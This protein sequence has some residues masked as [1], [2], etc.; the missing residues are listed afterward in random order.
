MADS[1]FVAANK[2][3][4][5]AVQDQNFTTNA[6]FARKSALQTITTTAWRYPGPVK[7][8]SFQNPLNTGT[9]KTQ[10]GAVKTPASIHVNSQEMMLQV[11]LIGL[12][13]FGMELKSKNTIAPVVTYITGA[14]TTVVASSGTVNGLEL[15][16]ATNFAQNQMIEIVMGSGVNAHVEYRRIETLSG[17]VVTFDYPLFVAPADGVAVKAVESIDYSPGG[18]GLQKWSGL[19]VHSGDEYS[20][21]LIHYASHLR[22][23]QGNVELPDGNVGEIAV[24]FEVFPTRVSGEPV[25]LT[26]RLQFQNAA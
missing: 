24:Q 6:F 23:P 11:N 3:P 1:V 17:A 5:L 25:F 8:G 26:E 20:D 22:V 15:T 16:S 10:L 2:A 18:S 9:N 12:T 13:P 14:S 19:I 21:R 7:P 4:L